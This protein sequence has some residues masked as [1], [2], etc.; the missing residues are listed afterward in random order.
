MTLPLP[1]RAFTIHSAQSLPE[2][3]TSQSTYETKSL[4]GLPLGSAPHGTTFAPAPVACLIEASCACPKS[5]IRTMAFAPWATMEFTSEI[6]FWRSPPPTVT[7]CLTFGHFAASERTAAYDSCDQAFTPKPSA[8][9]RV[10]GLVPQN[11]LSLVTPLF[12]I[13]CS[14]VSVGALA[15]GAAAV[16]PLE[17]S[18]E[19]ELPQADTTMA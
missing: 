4:P 2:A 3:G 5:G 10:S 6:D 12:W 15:A 1:C 11:D 17:V 9:P 16:P 13:S 19:P 14:A 8:T 7:I 18:L